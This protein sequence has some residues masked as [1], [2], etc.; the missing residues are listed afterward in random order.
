MTEFNELANTAIEVELLGKKYKVR[1][2]PLNTI[3]GKAE[4][5]VLSE[6]MKRI[7]SMADG[8]EGDD[9]ASFL[10]KAM[11]D[12]IPSGHRLNEM[13]SSYLRSIAGVRM[14]LVDAL[15][16]DQPDI[17]ATVDIMDIIAKED[18]KVASI[19]TFCIGGAGKK[20]NSPLAPSAAKKEAR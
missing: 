8:L 18:S 5:A 13:S 12:S 4:A 3:F 1:R 19:I 11:I 15:I 6:Q 16:V 20:S 17:E 9:K 7:H 2:V 10:A 14:V